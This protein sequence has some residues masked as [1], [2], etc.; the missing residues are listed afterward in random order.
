MIIES[1]DNKIFKKLLSLEKK[2][3]IFKENSILLS[4]KKIIRDY[5]EKKKRAEEKVEKKIIDKTADEITNKSEQRTNEKAKQQQSHGT[6]SSFENTLNSQ[7]IEHQHKHRWIISSSMESQE[8]TNRTL[9]SPELFSTLD[10]F[11]TKAPLLEVPC[12]QIGEINDWDYLRPTV[13]LSMGNP[14]NLGTFIRTA[15]GFGVQQAVLCKEACF[16]YLPE[17]IRASSGYALDFR[18]F[19]GPSIQNIEELHPKINAKN[20]VALDL[21][22]TQLSS[23][24]SWPDP[25]HLLIGEEGQGVPSKFPGLRY[26]IPLHSGVES[27]NAAVAGSI[28]LFHWSQRT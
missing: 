28:G 4:G 3:G 16:P 18:F 7:S 22:G 25:L 27:L 17:V 15:L 24:T 11:G 2:K 12:P 10:R 21:G 1:R 9:F 20:I 14:K 23:Q 5:L 19:K 26:E 6:K 8:L 13:I